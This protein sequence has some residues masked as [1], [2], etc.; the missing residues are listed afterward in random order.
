MLLVADRWNDSCH[1]SSKSRELDGGARACDRREVSS[2]R[3]RE[4]TFVDD[5]N[6]VVV[7]DVDVDAEKSLLG[8]VREIHEMHDI[9]TL[10]KFLYVKRIKNDCISGHFQR[11]ERNDL[12]EDLNEDELERTTSQKTA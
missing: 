10:K 7:V 11:L 12:N 3:Y 1:V 8:D 9:I 6:D 4:K 2:S 5:V